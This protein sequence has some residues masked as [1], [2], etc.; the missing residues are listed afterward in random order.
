MDPVTAAMNAFM[1]FNQFLCTPA[2]QQLASANQAIISKI[3]DHL[4]VHLAPNPAQ[5]ALAEKPV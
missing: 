3:L 5:V 4:G 1:A 2:G